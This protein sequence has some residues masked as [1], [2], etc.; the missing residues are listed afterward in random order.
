MLG[1]PYYVWTK[2]RNKSTERGKEEEGC[3]LRASF[4]VAKEPLL[5]YDRVEAQE[6]EVEI[7]ERVFYF[8]FFLSHRGRHTSSRCN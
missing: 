4:V 1:N 8:C 5:Q 3:S 6:E 2:R 7:A